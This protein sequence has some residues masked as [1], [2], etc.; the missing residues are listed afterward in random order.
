[1][2]DKS[3]MVNPPYSI[4]CPMVPG[5]SGLIGL[6]TTWDKCARDVI[7][8]GCAFMLILEKPLGFISGKC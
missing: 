3:A 5:F 1:M 8:S 7:F 2:E 4:T 6:F